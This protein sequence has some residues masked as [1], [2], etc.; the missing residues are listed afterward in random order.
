MRNAQTTAITLCEIAVVYKNAGT[1]ENGSF[2]FRHF[3]LALNSCKNISQIEDSSV[4][5]FSN[6]EVMTFCK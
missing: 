5:I 1:G 2:L 4:F 6:I 3:R